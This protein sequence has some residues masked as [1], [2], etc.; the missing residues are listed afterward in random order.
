MDLTLD[1]KYQSRLLRLSAHDRKINR[2]NESNSDFTLDIKSSNKELKKVVATQVINVQIPNVFYNIPQGL[3]VFKYSVA[4]VPQP[5]IVIPEGQYTIEQ[6][7]EV[8]LGLL[9]T[10]LLLPAGSSTYDFN[11]PNQTP[12]FKISIT[13]GSAIE[14]TSDENDNPIAFKLGYGDASYSGTVFDAPNIINLVG[15]HTVSIHSQ[16][17]SNPVLDYGATSGTIRLIAQVP[18]DKSFGQMCYFNATTSSDL[19]KYQDVKSWNQIR[20]ILRDNQGRRL[21][22]QN[23]DWSVTLKVWYLL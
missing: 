18:L 12:D 17:I 14:F 5:D 21:N 9:D 10:A 15:P 13:A 2:A 3:N 23:H 7:M 8:F 11:E 6:L 4:S 16:E 20:L 19:I 22:V 1:G